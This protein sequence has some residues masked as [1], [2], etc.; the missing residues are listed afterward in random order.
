MLVRLNS[1]GNTDISY[2]G[3]VEQLWEYRPELCWS[4]WLNSCGNIDMSYV[5]QVEQ[6]WEHRHELCWSG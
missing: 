1:C 3:Q 5:G 4:G 6:L 2:V